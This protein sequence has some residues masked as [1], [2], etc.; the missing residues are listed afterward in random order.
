MKI[1]EV[2]KRVDLEDGIGKGLKVIAGKYGVGG[3]E[4]GKEWKLVGP[5]H[6]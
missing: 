6:K 5:A 3:E 2:I 4:V 1:K